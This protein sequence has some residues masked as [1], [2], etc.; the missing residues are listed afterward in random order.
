MRPI[1]SRQHGRSGRQV[2]S[3]S[4][5]RVCCHTTRC[6]PLSWPLGLTRCA[7]SHRLACL[8]TLGLRLAARGDF[9]ISILGANPRRGGRRV[10]PVT[11]RHHALRLSIQLPSRD[12][13]G[14]TPQVL[15]PGRPLS[16][17]I[18]RMAEQPGL[19]FNLPRVSQHPPAA[20]CLQPQPPS[21]RPRLQSNNA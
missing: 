3:G 9:Q 8:P 7:T 14:P 18:P 2:C 21:L 13:R 10:S 4:W 1:P 19:L 20:L 11:L 15:R 16:Q 6:W 12:S 17:A 5:G